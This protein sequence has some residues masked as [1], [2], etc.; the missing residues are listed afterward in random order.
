M[1]LHSE[2]TADFESLREEEFAY[3]DE[4]GHRYFD[5]TGSGLAQSSQLDACFGILRGSTLGNPHSR[6]PT[7][8]PA[9]DL[10]AY[11]AGAAL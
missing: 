2:A 10:I 3:L 4:Q 6:N 7:S 1:A 8:T 5:Y 9:T 11:R